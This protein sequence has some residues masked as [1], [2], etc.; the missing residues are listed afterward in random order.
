MKLHVDSTRFGEESPKTY[1]VPLGQPHKV[2]CN[3]PQTVPEARVSWILK[4]GGDTDERHLKS[5]N[6]R[7]ISSDEKVWLLLS[8]FWM[9]MTLQGNIYFHYVRGEDFHEDKYFTC[10]VENEVLNEFKFG[11]QFQIKVDFSDHVRSE[12]FVCLRLELPS[13]LS[14]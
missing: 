2:S 5:F 14:V 4:S 11:N 1:T 6:E 12:L 10:T 7:S 3:V 8:V 13:P 9:N